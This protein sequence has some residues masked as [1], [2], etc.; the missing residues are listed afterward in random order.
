MPYEAFKETWEIIEHTESFEIRGGA[1]AICYIYFEDEIVRR[2][3][4]G[5]RMTKADAREVAEAIVKVPANETKP[6][7]SKYTPSLPRKRTR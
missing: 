4:F 2:M 3:A 7:A 6:K 1:K 5:K